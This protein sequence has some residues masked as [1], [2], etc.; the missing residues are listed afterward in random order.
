MEASSC[1]INERPIIRKIKTNENHYPLRSSDAVDPAKY[2][3]K[4][5]RIEPAMLDIR[6]QHRQLMI[7]GTRAQSHFV[8]GNARLPSPP[9]QATRVQHTSVLVADCDCVGPPMLHGKKKALLVT[10]PASLL[11]FVSMNQPPLCLVMKRVFGW[12][13]LR[14]DWSRA[15][16]PDGWAMASVSISVGWDAMAMKE[17]D[18]PSGAV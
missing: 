16:E 7:V 14:S 1:L 18:A 12:D 8:L 13:I 2:D 6:A 11:F 10:Y 3:T 9:K 17:R 4:R 5:V 15:E